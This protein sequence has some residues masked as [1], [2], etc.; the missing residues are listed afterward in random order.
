MDQSMKNTKICPKC[1]SSKIVRFDCHAGGHG[2]N[3][4]TTSFVSAVTI[5]RYIC[6]RCG[7]VEE[8]ID[9]GDLEEI[10]NSKK[11]ASTW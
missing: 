4:V 9:V 8:W 6:C 10:E 5:N 2:G 7:Y 11:A 1:Q 3:F